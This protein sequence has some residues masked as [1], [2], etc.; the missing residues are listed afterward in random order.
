VLPIFMVLENPSSSARSEPANLASIG[1]HDN[2]Y[3]TEGDFCVKKNS[4]FFVSKKLKKNSSSF[5]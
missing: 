5:V 3:T 1:K 4:K 2:H